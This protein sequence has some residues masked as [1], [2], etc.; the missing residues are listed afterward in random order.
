MACCVDKTWMREEGEG[1]IERGRERERE[2]EGEERERERER[3]RDH[4]EQETYYCVPDIVIVRSI[5][6]KKTC[7]YD[8]HAEYLHASIFIISIICLIILF[9]LL[10]L[11][12]HVMAQHEKY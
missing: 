9:G 1:W 4:E 12:S 6:K 5:T 2:R 10:I 3:A 11:Q 7:H 8:V